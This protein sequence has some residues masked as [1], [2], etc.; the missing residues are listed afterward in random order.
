MTMKTYC[1][2]LLWRSRLPL[3]I[4]LISVVS[5]PCAS[6]R[7]ADIS[8]SVGGREALGRFSVD[9]GRAV[10]FDGSFRVP[11]GAKNVQIDVSAPE[12]PPA[13]KAKR[14]HE[15][16]DDAIVRHGMFKNSTPAGPLP[17]AHL[18][19]ED[20][21]RPIWDGHD[22]ALRCFAHVFEVT[23]RDYLRAPT[24][25]NGFTRNYVYTPFGS[26]VFMWGTCYI[27]MYGR[28]AQHI[29]PFI[30]MLDNFYGA[31]H[32][33]GFIP[34]SI[35]LETGA[36]D[37]DKHD[38]ASMGGNLLAWAEWRNW[39]WA[40]DKARLE[41]VYP[42]L[43]AFH[44]WMRENR[45]W[46]DGSYF[47]NGLGCGMDNIPRVDTS[48]YNVYSHHGYLAWL[49]V[50][51]QQIWNAKCLLRMADVIGTDEGVAELEEES[52]R[53]AAFA[54][55]KMWDPKAGIYK[56]LDRDGRRIACSHVGTFW[57]L[58]AGI[59][60]EA[61]I[62]ALERAAFDPKRF[63][64]ACG[65]ASTSIDSK[66]FKADGGN[67]WQGGTW[68]IMDTMA[69]K[70][71]ERAGRPG[72]AHRL[73]R[74][75]VEAVAKVFADTGFIWESYHP[76]SV[77]PGRMGN[78]ERVRRFVGFCG[79]VPAELLVE[80]VIGIRCERTEDGFGLVWDVRLLERHGIE[81]LVLADGTR[82]DLVCEARKSAEEKPR[83]TIR[84]SRPVRIEVRSGA[85]K[86][87]SPR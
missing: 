28:Y 7:D 43:L 72:T 37:G 84:S 12:L 86:D 5:A 58:L 75:A 52:S 55:D 32:E 34:R 74:H 41:K 54:N 59:A 77:E 44:R 50:T 29:F 11:G 70:G 23:G 39:E 47:S 42:Y 4:L 87:G 81:N 79:S 8:V 64:A 57:A 83:T 16:T 78:G 65:L 56:D 17:E 76:C 26:K 10:V 33:D 71:F 31:Q 45:T 62:D 73:A 53:L 46:K 36:M 80:N 60:D 18:W 51:L 24:E 63:Y 21:P 9:G 15:R 6:A 20:V 68:C 61:K 25:E 67:Y 38:L 2:N 40:G 19:T 30:D 14:H 3:L 48:R 85:S 82:V 27:T 35:H 66:G 13:R 22:D 1:V 69:V 49:D